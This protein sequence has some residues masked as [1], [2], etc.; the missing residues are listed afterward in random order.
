MVYCQF[1]LETHV[2][3][4]WKWIKCSNVMSRLCNL[5]WLMLKSCHLGAVPMSISRLTSMSSYQM[6]SYRNRIST[7]RLSRE[8]FIF[9]VI[10]SYLKDRLYNETGS[11]FIPQVPGCGINVL[12]MYPT[13]YPTMLVVH[14]TVNSNLSFSFISCTSVVVDVSIFLA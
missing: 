6:P 8:R 11:R 4:I 3:G 7:V 2:R 9:K 13:N 14:R 12:R 5:K 10:I 1:T